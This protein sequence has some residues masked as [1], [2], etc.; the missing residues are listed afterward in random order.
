MAQRYE[1]DLGN[2]LR[3]ALL[4]HRTQSDL[5]KLLNRRA[6]ELD[7]MERAQLMETEG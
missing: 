5:D 4:L 2:G 7:P 6:D 1:F 3:V